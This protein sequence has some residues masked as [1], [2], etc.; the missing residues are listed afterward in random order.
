MKKQSGF[1]YKPTKD[2]KY[3][4]ELA[5]RILLEVGGDRTTIGELLKREP[6][7][8]RIGEKTTGT[9]IKVDANNER[10]TVI[11]KKITSH[12]IEF[13]DGFRYK[14]SKFL[15]GEVKKRYNLKAV[16]FNNW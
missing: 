1:K 8:I 6:V 3:E 11:V 7:L 15:A 16:K 13:K 9:K 10:Q 4:S 2:E 14:V 12:E 5:T